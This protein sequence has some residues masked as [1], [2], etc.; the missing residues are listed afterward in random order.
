MVVTSST[1]MNALRR[2][3]MKIPKIE[4]SGRLSANS[5]ASPNG[6]SW[7]DHLATPRIKERATS[8]LNMRHLAPSR[9]FSTPNLPQGRGNRVANLSK[10][11][12]ESALRQSMLPPTSNF[13]Q[14]HVYH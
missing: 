14:T 2:S 13:R 6:D 8:F 9:G 4:P 5:S 3:I 1:S 11:D 10:D 7:L 12:K